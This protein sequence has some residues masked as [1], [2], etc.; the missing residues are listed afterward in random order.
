MVTSL[1]FDTPK[2]GSDRSRVQALIL[3]TG[4][5]GFV[6]VFGSYGFIAPWDGDFNVYIA[7]VHA[8][9]RN[10]WQPSDVS[11][12]VPTG[13]AQIYSPY[14]ILVALTGKLLGVTPYRALQFAGIVNIALYAAAVT[15]FCRRFSR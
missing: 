11:L 14:L 4:L 13:N 2:S 7:A 12:G 9:Y 15:A 6:V 3:W 5:A 1:V 8:L 10:L